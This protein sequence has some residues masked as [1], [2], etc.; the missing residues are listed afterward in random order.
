MRSSGAC[1]SFRMCRRACV[2][3]VLRAAHIA[4]RQADL[5]KADEIAPRHATAAGGRAV[6]SS[7]ELAAA[8]AQRGEIDGIVFAPLNKHAMRLA[9]LVQEDELRLLQDLFHV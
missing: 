8:A 5:I 1:C 3:S 4:V 2:V 6:L 9:G 7:L